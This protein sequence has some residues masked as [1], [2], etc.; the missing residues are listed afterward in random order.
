MA[1]HTGEPQERGSGVSECGVVATHQMAPEAADLWCPK[2]TK[3]WASVDSAFCGKRPLS[4]AG[5]DG[6]KSWGEM[7]REGGQCGA[8]VRDSFPVGCEGVRHGGGLGTMWPR[9]GGRSTLV[10]LGDHRRRRESCPG[11]HELAVA[12]ACWL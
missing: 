2:Q 7:N 1:P 6:E 11:G 9:R 8:P 12:E 4:H 5:N 10:S 3:W